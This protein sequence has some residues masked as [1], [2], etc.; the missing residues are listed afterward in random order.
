MAEWEPIQGVLPDSPV[1]EVFIHQSF[2]IVV[3]MLFHEVQQFVDNDV[4]QAILGFLCQ[5]QVDPDALGKDVTGAPFGLH[6]FDRPL[7]DLQ[8]DD[9]LPLLDHGLHSGFEPGPIPLLQHQRTMPDRGSGLFVEIDVSATSQFDH[10]DAGVRNHIQEIAFSFQ[11][12]TFSCDVLPMGKALHL[13]E[14][15]DVLFDPAK[16]GDD[17]QAD[18]LIIHLLG[19]GDP[20]SPGGWI[21][22]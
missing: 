18:A 3:V 7:V 5:F 21:D 10:V 9:F 16:F 17:V 19:N 6:L 20:D 2:E 22:R 1:G 8:S 11:I 12:V 15:G 13:F 4:F 14:S